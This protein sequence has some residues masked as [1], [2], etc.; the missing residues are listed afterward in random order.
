MRKVY[1][2]NKNN[3][4]FLLTPE[5]SILKNIPSYELRMEIIVND[6]KID[7]LYIVIFPTKIKL[8]LFKNAFNDNYLEDNYLNANGLYLFMNQ[9]KTDRTFDKG[10]NI[11][12]IRMDYLIDNYV[13]AEKYLRII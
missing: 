9:L 13:E 10:I 6:I 7:L 12:K 2:K 4:I 5:P 11:D 1:K 8:N 3:E